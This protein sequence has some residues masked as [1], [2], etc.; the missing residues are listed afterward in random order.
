MYGWVFASTS[1][2]TLTDT[3]ATRPRPAATVFNTSN[4]AADSRLKQWMPSSR[5]RAISPGFLLTPEN[6][7]FDGAPP[8]ATTRS[9]SPPETMSKPAPS[10]ASTLSTARLE[11]AFTAIADQVLSPFKGPAVF[12]KSFFQRGPGIDVAGSAVQ[13]CDRADGNIFCVQAALT[14]GEM[15]HRSTAPQGSLVCCTAA[16]A[17][18]AGWVS[19]VV[20]GT[21][22]GGMYS[23]PVCPH[24]PRL[25]NATAIS[26]AVTA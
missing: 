26:R 24:P 7:I 4:S 11:L 14:I 23:G 5:A 3:G 18:A 21:G 10:L 20:A 8:A 25:E 9:S 13:G 12:H 6:T 1:G 2:L 22:S 17:G 19:G 15:V 16:S